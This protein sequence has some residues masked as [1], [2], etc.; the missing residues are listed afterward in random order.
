MT[1]FQGEPLALP[2]N[3]RCLGM[4]FKAPC[5]LPGS[6]N[7]LGLLCAFDIVTL[8]ACTSYALGR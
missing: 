3:C 4:P 2:H 1:D 5:S 6:G 8:H 7:G